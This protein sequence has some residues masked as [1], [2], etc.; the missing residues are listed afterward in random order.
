MRR[1]LANMTELELQL[2]ALKK[3]VFGLNDKL[4]SSDASFV[5]SKAK[6][7][8]RKKKIKSLTKSLDNL[9]T[10]VARLSAA[11]NQAT[12]LEAER[13]EEILRLKTTPPEFS[14]FFWVQFQGLVQKFLA[15][16]KFSRVQ[17]E[18]LS[19]AASS[20]FERGLSMHRTKDEFV[21]VL[22]KMVNFMPG[23]HDR[24][25]EASPL[26]SFSLNLKIGS[27]TNVPTPRDARVSPPVAKESTVTPASKSLE[28]STNVDLT[29]FV[30]AFEHNEGMGMSVVLDDVAELTG[31][32]S[33]HVSS[34]PNDVVVA[35]S[36]SEKGDGLT[37]STVAGEE[38]A[39]NPSRV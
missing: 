21:D 34:G 8:E 1:R 28:I 6:G 33:G 30:V 5:K 19:L 3:Q 39:V 12:I 35:L 38:D 37:P 2:S 17:G 27:S 9:H 22:K 36:A 26:L 10:K 15:S 13:D 31:V 20:G 23:A 14:S 32:G 25:A 29:A 18:L 16:D 24:L 4:S 7:N 11:L